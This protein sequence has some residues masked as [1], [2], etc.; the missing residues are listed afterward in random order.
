MAFEAQYRA[1][2][3]PVGMMEKILADRVIT[4][5]W[6]LQRLA[7]VETEL[8]NNSKKGKSDESERIKGRSTE[9]IQALAILSRYEATLE[10]SMFTALHALQSLQAER[11]ATGDAAPA[12]APVVADVEVT[13]VWGSMAEQ[14]REMRS[15]MARKSGK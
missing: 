10:R 12:P 6:R 7:R 9:E 11:A 5:A 14:R 4:T 2:L 1:T 15:R 3:Q 8:F 13:G